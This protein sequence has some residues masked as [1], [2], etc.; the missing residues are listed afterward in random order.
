MQIVWLVNGNS[1]NADFQF[2]TAPSSLLNQGTISGLAV[3]T[4]QV[5]VG[6]A[7]IS[8]TSNGQ[9][10]LITYH[11][12][13]VVTIDTSGTKK[14][15]IDVTQSKID[16]GVANN[17]DG[18][19]IAQINTGA[20]YPWSGSY[21]PLASITGGVIT[22]DRVFVSMKNVKRKGMAAHRLIY[23]DASGNESELPYGTAGQVLTAVNGTTT[24][25]WSSPN[26]DINGLTAKS[27]PKRADKA[28]IAD[29]DASF[30]NKNITLWAIESVMSYYG[31]GS[32]DD[33]TISGTVT[34]TRDMYY[35]NLTL[36]D[37]SI[38]K[39]NWFKIYV[40]WTLSR[41][42]TGYID[43]SGWNGW[44]WA[45]GW[46]YTPSAGNAWSAGVAAYTAWTLPVPFSWKPWDYNSAGTWNNNGT[47][48]S[49]WLIY[50]NWTTSWF[51][52]DSTES[53]PTTKFGRAGVWWGSFTA[54][55]NTLH[56]IQQVYHLLD[57]TSSVQVCELAPSS[58]WWESA[59]TSFC[60]NGGWSWANWG[61]IYAAI[62]TIN[63]AWAT[64]VFRAKGGNGWNGGNWGIYSSTYRWGGGGGGSGWQGGLVIIITWY[65]N[66]TLSSF[67]DVSGWTAGAW[68]IKNAGNNT[69]YATDWW[70]W[71]AWNPGRIVVYN[72]SA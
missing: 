48:T 32:D 43:V 55:T 52:W 36:S 69:L 19:G 64:A 49:R 16:N 17:E 51:W 71:S 3:T 27:A 54:S 22:D 1:N 37:G 33:V 15:W 61:A 57:I 24:P 72:L 8:V 12:T 40:N 35:N 44:A 11:N 59:Q 28:I 46:N 53:W 39:T 50:V 5:W 18:T 10:W 23:I 29:S 26:V 7:L 45:D 66:V 41:P 6:S 68:W 47:S 21:I 65:T 60:W 14:V 4:N 31:D 34:L 38:L 63:I 13:S 42:W 62:R 9:T 25:I 56:S 70:P 67:I 58:A 30:V 20:S 2:Q